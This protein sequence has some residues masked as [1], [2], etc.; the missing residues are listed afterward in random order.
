MYVLSQQ[1]WEGK[2]IKLKD[3]GKAIWEIRRLDCLDSS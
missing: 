3:S 1:E 2:K